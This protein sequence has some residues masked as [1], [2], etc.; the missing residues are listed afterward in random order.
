MPIYS[1]INC[2]RFF[3]YSVN[4]QKKSYENCILLSLF[5]KI[6]ILKNIDRLSNDHLSG[7][8]FKIL[9]SWKPWELLI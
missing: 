9:Q 7:E 6:A 4:E 2:T 5:L 3:L 1:I 8:N